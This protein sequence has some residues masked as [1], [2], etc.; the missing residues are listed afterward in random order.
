MDPKGN[1]LFLFDRGTQYEFKMVSLI[2]F[3]IKTPEIYIFL[4]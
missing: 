4:Y 1:I 3:G 2:K